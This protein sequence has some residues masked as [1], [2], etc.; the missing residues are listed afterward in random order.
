MISRADGK[1]HVL[2]KSAFSR[3]N[4]IIVTG[5]REG[6]SFIAKKY[7]NTPWHRVELIDEVYEDGTISTRVRGE[8]D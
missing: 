8:E 3:G 1:K 7:K 6:D 2:E 5:I 4:K